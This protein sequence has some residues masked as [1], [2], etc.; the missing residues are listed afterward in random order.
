M[1]HALVTLIASDGIEL[2][3]KA[4]GGHGYMQSSGLPSLFADYVPA[5]TYEGENNV[6]H[7]QTARFLI[8][9]GRDAMKGNKTHFNPGS[10]FSYLYELYGKAGKVSCQAKNESDFLD[11]KV[12]LDAY[13]HRAASL[14]FDTVNSLTKTLQ[15]GV[16]EHQAWNYHILDLIRCSK[17]HVYY[18]LVYHFAQTVDN[19]PTD[20]TDN[21][22]VLKKLKDLFA[23]W[24]TETQI[25]EFMENGY[26]SVQQVKQIREQ[27]KILLNEICLYAVPLVDGFDLHDH[28]LQ[29]TLGR[30]DGNVYQALFDEAKRSPLNKV[31]MTDGFNKYLK[32]KV[33][34]KL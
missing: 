3:R 29:S 18:S 32:P 2:C 25:G 27:V 24:N 34:S 13:R 20:N 33:V 5:C 31:H 6:M 4:C 11:T 23:L 16:P 17:A 26:L 7:L 22:L 1:Q 21:K 12:Q 14:V 15:K 30:Y 10:M 28:E 19:L 9:I 8:K